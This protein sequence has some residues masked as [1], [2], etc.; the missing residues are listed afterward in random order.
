MR[1]RR[2][3]AWLLNTGWSGGGFGVGRRI[4]LR[5]TRALVDA[6]LEGMLH[7]VSYAADPIFGVEYPLACPGVPSEIL[8]PRST[9]ADPAAYDAQ[10]HRLACRFRDN[11]TRFAGVAPAIQAA[12][13]RIGAR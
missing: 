3:D 6:V 11:F 2:I 7:D 1:Q 9:W 5:H 8:S 13:P 4:A 12:G 10:A